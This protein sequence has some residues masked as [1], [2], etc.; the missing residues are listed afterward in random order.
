[1]TL[2]LCAILVKRTVRP[3]SVCRWKQSAASAANSDIL[4]S[5]ALRKTGF[6]TNERKDSCPFLVCLSLKTEHQQLGSQA[7]AILVC[8]FSSEL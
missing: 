5:N 7:T 8:C 2:L 3:L 6:A 1:V 4:V